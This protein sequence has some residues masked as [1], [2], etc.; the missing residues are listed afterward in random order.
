[1]RRSSGLLASVITSV[2][3]ILALA[4]PAGAAAQPEVFTT[5]KHNVTLASESFPDDICGSRAV[6]ET[7]TNTVQVNHLTAND[8]GSFHFVDFET[9][10]LVADYANPGIPDQTF[11]RINTEVVN[12]T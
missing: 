3:G 11:R 1:M 5:I 8:D 6:T 7:V 10:V 9:G 2:L 4:M 12:L